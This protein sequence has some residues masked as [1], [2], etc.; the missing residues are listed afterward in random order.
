[1][2]TVYRVQNEVGRGP[3]HSWVAPNMF[4]PLGQHQPV[5]QD[6]FSVF[7]GADL[8]YQDRNAMDELMRPYL[9]GFPT[10]EA[11]KAWWSEQ[12]LAHMAER[13]YNLVA[14]PAAEV[15]VSDSGRQCLFQPA[16]PAQPVEGAPVAAVDIAAKVK[17]VASTVA[18]RVGEALSFSFTYS[19]LITPKYDGQRL[20]VSVKDLT[21][22]GPSGTLPP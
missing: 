3:Y 6:D 8:D 18:N 1:M 21:P 7:R 16:G 4:G 20:K 12:D 13:G 15:V 2:L 11:A 5:P 22:P 17:A 19:L 14:L 10:L 9:F